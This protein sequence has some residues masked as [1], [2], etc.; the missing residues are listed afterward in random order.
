MS[1]LQLSGIQLPGPRQNP[2]LGKAWLTRTGTTILPVLFRDLA[3]EPLLSE[4]RVLPP[5]LSSHR[6]PDVLTGLPHGGGAVVACVPWWVCELGG[7]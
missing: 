4:V 7:P 2:A 5:S 1:P 3:P 6:H